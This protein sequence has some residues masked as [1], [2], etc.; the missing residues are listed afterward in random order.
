MKERLFKR[1]IRGGVLLFLFVVFGCSVNKPFV[2]LGEEPY[3]KN[4]ENAQAGNYVAA[5]APLSIAFDAASLNKE[6]SGWF[7]L[8]P[9]LE[10]Y[11]GLIKNSL[12]VSRVFKNILEETIRSMEDAWKAGA[13][14]FIL[15]KLVE[16]QVFYSG[17]NKLFVPNII[18]WFF[19]EIPSWFV[20]DEVYG[21]RGK[22]EFSFISTHSGR[23]LLTCTAEFNVE[24]S[25]DDF[26]RG[27]QIFGIL[28]VPGSL[29]ESN[30]LKIAETLKEYEEK[31]VQFS[32]VKVMNEMVRSATA[33]DSFKRNMAKRCG[34]VIGLSRYRSE[35]LPRL[36]FADDDAIAFRNLLLTSSRETTAERNI[37]ILT[38][39]IATKEAFFR[40]LDSLIKRL[41]PED[42]VVLYFA[43][44]GARRLKKIK[45]AQPSEPKEEEREK[46]N[47]GREKR[48]ES[49]D[50]DEGEKEKGEEK[51]TAPSEES[52]K[53]E[54]PPP[55]TVKEHNFAEPAL[56]LFDS[57]PNNPDTFI[58]LLDILNLLKS[59]NAKVMVIIID[60]GFGTEKLLRGA[61]IDVG[62]TPPLK[63]PFISLVQEKPFIIL[64]GADC[65]SGEGAAEFEHQKR[66]VATFYLLEGA[67]GRADTDKNGSVSLKEAFLYLYP[68]VVEETQMEACT[69]HPFILGSNTETVI[70]K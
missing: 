13:D 29:E 5:V 46:G 1:E 53:E 58:S 17:T 48:E 15:P 31:E 23:E 21:L 44:Y 34:L 11:S 7:A 43:G 60:A 27:W 57:D 25:L 3:I 65:F 26:E 20:K 50:E 55:T 28:R 12:K 19:F 41:Q 6:A 54:E 61:G 33:S 64:C 35:A 2:A 70:L 59:G 45:E 42:E 36:K 63:E 22:I 40:E 52:K 30:W 49:S 56:L 37:K 68:R 9:S 32:I 39:D 62:N 38:N 24:R 10:R 8:N 18:N 4:L 16:Y 47:G 66:G 51:K 69:Q 67:S 14:V